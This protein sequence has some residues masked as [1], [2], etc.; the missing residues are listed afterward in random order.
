MAEAKKWTPGLKVIRFHGPIAERTRLK[1][2]VVGEI[3]Y[4]GN[5]T[6]QARK[7][8][9][10]K[11]HRGG[12][13]QHPISLDTESDDEDVG[14]DLVVTTYD[15]FKCEQSWFKTAF[16][17]RYI[18]LD[19]GH[20]VSFFSFFSSLQTMLTIFQVKNSASG[21]SKSLQGIKAEYRLILT[22][23]PLQNNLQELWSLLAWLYPEVFV[24][25]T[26]LLFEKSF[27]L[28]KGQFSGSVLDDSRRLLEV[29]M[30][31]RMKTSPGVEL[32]LPPKT[33]VLLFVPLSP[34]QRFWYTRMIT[35][36]DQGLLDELFKSAKAK[37]E[38]AMHNMKAI[39]AR[40]AELA[41]M[42]AE[43]LKVCTKFPLLRTPPAT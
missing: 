22:G 12:A 26:N 1:K 17:W 13:G 16:V 5:L 40:E 19:E 41:K 42:E 32:N 23:T 34:M 28:S 35:K 25:K 38:S 43:A 15:S 18:V 29:I 3:D 39:E 20:T 4:Y 14:V 37:E 31:R 6:A 11:Q 8:K 33:E 21:I 27:N 24:A 36:A 10:S 30:L 9:N 7:K 2:V